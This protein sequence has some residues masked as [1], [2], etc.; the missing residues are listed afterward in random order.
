MLTTKEQRCVIKK[1]IDCIS[2]A[3]ALD[4]QPVRRGE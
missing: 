4:V 3:P 2:D 1:T